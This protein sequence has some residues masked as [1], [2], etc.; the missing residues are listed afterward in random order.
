MTERTPLPPTPP[1]WFEDFHVGL[2]FTS[3]A[4]T[5]CD[6]DVRAYARF[7][8]DIRPLLNPSGDQRLRVPNMYLFS[9]SVGL[10][11]HGPAGYIPE[12]FVA[13][14]GFDEISFEAP[15]YGGDTI[16]SVARVT[17]V[18]ERGRN[19]ILSYAH[20]ALR[21]D[22]QPL[23]SSSQRILVERRDGHA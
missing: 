12:K 11:L 3:P 19:G 14:F 1:T 13:F 17:A 8:N 20:R 23:V 18:V 7:A 2:E 21:S 6:D 4:R 10:L 15:A 5:V 16:Y 9:L 22:G